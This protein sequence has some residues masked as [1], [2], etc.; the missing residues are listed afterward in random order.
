MKKTFTILLVSAVAVWGYVAVQVVRV[1]LGKA[2]NAAQSMG[3]G[4]VAALALLTR[5]QVPF[6]TAFRDPFQSYLY[7][8]KPAPVLTPG[9]RTSKALVVIE[10]PRVVLSGV[11]WG[12][13]PVAI[14][15]QDGQTELVKKGAE[16]WGLKVLR[17]DRNQVVVAK[18]GRQFT[19]EY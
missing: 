12:D 19:L 16:I 10:P 5:V 7:A 2:T 18:Q 1:L 8:Q 15:K 11:L 3:T 14:L 6:D 13:E 9:P 17:I 4:P